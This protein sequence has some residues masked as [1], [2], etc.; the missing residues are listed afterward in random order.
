MGLNESYAQIREQVLM[1]EPLPVITKVFSI[2]VQEERHRSIHCNVSKIG[3]DQ[4]VGINSVTS[5]VATP[6]NLPIAARS[7]KN[8]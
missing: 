7:K 4:S 2:V 5:S 3:V 6:V 8:G 1:L